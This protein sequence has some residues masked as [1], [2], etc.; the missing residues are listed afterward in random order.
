[1]KQLF[2]LI[3]STCILMA[4]NNSAQDAQARQQATI[5]SMAQ[6]MAKQHVIDSMKNV[7]KHTQG[8]ETYSGSS[9]ANSTT[10]TTTT[11]K[12]WSAKAKGAV[13]GAGVGAITGALVDKNHGAGALIGGVAGAGLGYGTGAVIDNKKKKQAAQGQ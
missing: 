10:T 12:K 2:L 13:I 4:C 11:K 5:D 1:M 6:V 3:S 8:G 7:E 9:T